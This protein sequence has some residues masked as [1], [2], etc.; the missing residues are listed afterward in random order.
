VR[1]DLQK[2]STRNRK[3]GAE[4]EESMEQRHGHR[5]TRAS[6]C[7]QKEKGDVIGGAWCGQGKSTRTSGVRISASSLEKACE[8]ARRMKAIPY[9][10]LDFVMEGMAEM[11]RHWVIIPGPVFQV[12]KDRLTP[13][14]VERFRP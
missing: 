10:D 7:G 13:E 6:G 14:E 2:S 12:L 11:P 8:D 3:Q 4:H 1:P 5:R 9:F